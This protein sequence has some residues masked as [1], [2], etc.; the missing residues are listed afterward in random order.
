MPSFGLRSPVAHYERTSLAADPISCEVPPQ[1]PTLRVLDP[2]GDTRRTDCRV[3]G[4]PPAVATERRMR[5]PL[6]FEVAACPAAALVA[7]PTGGRRRSDQR[8]RR[9]RWAIRYPGG[10][11]RYILLLQRQH[12]FPGRRPG[13]HFPG[14]P[15]ASLERAGTIRTGRTA[16]C[17]RERQRTANE[18]CS[19]CSGRD[20]ALP[21]HRR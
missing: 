17:I 15:T 21:D 2:Q 1:A 8:R 18:S 19:R 12:R 13:S 16:P 5:W 20:R 7:A 11:S 4:G 10:P 14:G 9:A 3:V 6:E